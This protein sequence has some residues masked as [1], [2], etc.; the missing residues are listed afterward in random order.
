MGSCCRGDVCTEPVTGGKDQ[1]AQHD[2]HG[3]G[4]L[5]A[6]GYLHAEQTGDEPEGDHQHGHQWH[7]Q[8]GKALLQVGGADQRDGRHAQREGAEDDGLAHG[9]HPF[10]QADAHVGDDAS[11]RGMA[12]G[13]PGEDAQQ[14]QHDEGHQ[15]P[16]QVAQPAGLG[17]AQPGQGKQP[18]PHDD[19]DRHGGGGDGA[20]FLGSWGHGGQSGVGC[21]K[22]PEQPAACY[23]ATGTGRCWCGRWICLAVVRADARDAN[24]CRRVCAAISPVATG[25]SRGAGYCC[26]TST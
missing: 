12:A 3:N 11:G 7:G 21:G 4:R 6:T 24:A 10:T 19:G 2:G 17:K 15:Q 26:G 16:G 5:D 14:R 22:R 25:V 8:A 20:H 18:G 1:Q 23:R 9:S 13:E